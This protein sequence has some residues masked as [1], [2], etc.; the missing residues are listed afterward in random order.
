MIPIT[1]AAGLTVAGLVAG[2]VVVE[3][4]FALNGLGSYLVQSVG[5]KDIPVVQAICLIL[6]AAFVVINTVVDLLYAVLD[7]RIELTGDRP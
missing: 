7:P 2:A 1:T 3:N 5:Q 4:A 6:V